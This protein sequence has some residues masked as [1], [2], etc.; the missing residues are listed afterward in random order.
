VAGKHPRITQCYRTQHDTNVGR[1]AQAVE[2]KRQ[3]NKGDPCGDAGGSRTRAHSKDSGKHW[4]EDKRSTRRG[5]A[6][7]SGAQHSL[8]QDAKV[9]YTEPSPKRRNV[10]RRTFRGLKDRVL[11]APKYNRR[12]SV[13]A[14]IIGSMTEPSLRIVVRGHGVFVYKSRTEL[15][16]SHSMTEKFSPEETNFRHRFLGVSTRQQTGSR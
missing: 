2:F 9:G 8:L 5:A 16:H 15:L 4:L 7:G 11:I 3:S 1:C 10:E 12:K 13:C 14:G 6:V